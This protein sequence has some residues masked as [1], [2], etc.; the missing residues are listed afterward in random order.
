MGSGR[1]AVPLAE[2]GYAVTGVDLDPAML[3]RARWRARSAEPGGADRLTLVEADL[4]GLHLATAGTFGL[5]FIALNSLLVL[6][7]RAAQQAAVRALA[8]HLAPGGLAVID[9][10]IPDAEELTRFDG[11]ISLEWPRVD[12]ETGHIVTKAASAQHDS[13]SA[14]VVLTTIFEE[15][16]Q[17]TP[18]R[19]WVRRDRLRLVSAGELRSFAD[20]AGLVVELMAGDYGLGPIGP[21][22]ERAVLLAVKP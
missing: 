8:E 6:P 5:A 19:R 14:T 13:A 15:G 12:P 9:I 1:L 21:G 2:A 17:G 3:E 18:T 7:S 10:W 4:V 22:S 11:R 16:G 20:E